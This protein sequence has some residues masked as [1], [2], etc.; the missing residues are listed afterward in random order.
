MAVQT[1]H[2]TTVGFGTTTGWTPKYTSVA[3]PSASREVLRTSHLGTATAHTKIPGDLVDFGQYTCEYFYEPAATNAVPPIGAAAET[4]TVTNKGGV[5][6]I[7]T[8]FVSGF[9][10]AERVSDNL[11]RAN[12]TIE[13]AS[14]I[15]YA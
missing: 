13:V 8:G 12:L 4:I 11:M 2:G 3:G 9:D 7:F 10:T 1:G 14:T 6:E 5:T 15:A